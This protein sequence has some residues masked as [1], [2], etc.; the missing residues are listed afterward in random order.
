MEPTHSRVLW[1]NKETVRVPKLVKRG[2]MKK[3]VHKIDKESNSWYL[4]IFLI[5][6]FII[7]MIFFLYNCKDGLFKSMDTDSV[8]TPYSNDLVYKLQ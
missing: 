2:K 3:I 5:I 7:F 8:P 1:T 4:N 6:T